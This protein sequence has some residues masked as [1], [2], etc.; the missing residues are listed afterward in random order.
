[1]CPKPPVMLE[2][3]N[4]YFP[5]WHGGAESERTLR[6]TRKLRGALERFDFSEV[7]TA[8]TPDLPIADNVKAKG[9]LLENADALRAILERSRPERLRVLGGDC[10]VSF[11]PITHLNAV[12][13]G[14]LAVVWLDAHADI[15]TPASS[16]SK[17]FHG[18]VLRAALG[19]TDA[20][21]LE[22]AAKPIRPAQVFLGGV[23]DLDG[24]EREF[25]EAAGIRH[26]DSSTLNANPDALA[27]A[28]LE[29][30]FRKVYLHLDFDAF[31]PTE[32][33]LTRFPTP[34]GLRVATVVRLLER[35]RAAFDLVGF[36]LTECGPSDD[37]HWERHRATL[38][39]LLQ[40]LPFD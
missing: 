7:P 3:V 35:F 37:A 32:L 2:G 9:S 29:A 24:P 6:G 12:H 20:D 26:F 14:E 4:L 40:A 28:V 18:M 38:E 17:H 34:G 11:V 10:G 25:V 21:F 15:N 1:M 23:R 16:P 39:P 13:G 27:D 30:G 33:D 22:R 36:A 5:Q 8:T 19:E 31:E